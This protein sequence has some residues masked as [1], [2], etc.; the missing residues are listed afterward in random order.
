MRMRNLPWAEDC[1][2]EQEVVVKEPAQYKGTWK[3]MLDCT[4]LHV[5][6]GTGKGDYWT[7][8]SQRYPDFG[9]IGVEKNSSVAALTVRNFVIWKARMKIC[10]LSRMMQ[11]RLP[12]GLHMGKWMLF[13]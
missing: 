13:I 3:E 12:S 11:K 10:V 1:L 9:W 8:M 4:C 5:E 7:K 2:N 6:I